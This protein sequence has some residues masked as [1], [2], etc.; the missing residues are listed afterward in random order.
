MWNKRYF[1]LYTVVQVLF[2][3][4]MEEVGHAAVMD[5]KKAHGEESD[6]MR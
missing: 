1:F 4:V 3:F 6:H 2:D 5:P